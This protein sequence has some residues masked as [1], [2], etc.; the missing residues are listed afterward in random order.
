MNILKEKWFWVLSMWLLI[1]VGV[2]FWI[3]FGFEMGFILGFIGTK[4]LYFE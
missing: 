4:F 3:I 1:F 2:D